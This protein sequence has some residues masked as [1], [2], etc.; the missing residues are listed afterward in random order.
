MKYQIII[1]II[2]IMVIVVFVFLY[3]SLT[4]AVQKRYQM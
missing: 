1:I 3:D 2:I 4:D